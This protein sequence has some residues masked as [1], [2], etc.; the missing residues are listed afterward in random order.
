MPIITKTVFWYGQNITVNVNV[1]GNFAYSEI[2]ENI[3]VETVLTGT[4]ALHNTSKA[5][6][7]TQGAI[8][9]IHNYA[10]NKLWLVTALDSMQR[11]ITI[12][13]QGKVNGGSHNF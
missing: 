12:T 2:D 10:E 7:A 3:I 6:G 5:N 13:K 1:T 11:T 8:G 4:K 9:Y